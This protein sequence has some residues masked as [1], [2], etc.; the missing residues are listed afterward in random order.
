MY[1]GLVQME[2]PFF[3]AE[4]PPEPAVVF[5][6]QRRARKYILRICPD[7]SL[8]VTIPRGGSRRGAEAFVSSQRQWTERERL[9]V[10]AQ[11]APVV[12][13]RNDRI[14]L[15]GVPVPLLVERHGGASVLVLG[16]ARVRVREDG[17]NLRGAAETALR[18]IAARDLIPRLRQ[19]AAR[20]GLEVARVTIR[21]QRTRWGSC[22][23]AGA[24]ALNFRLVQMPPEVCDYVLVHE[25][26]HLRQQD[27][28]RKFWRL[29]EQACPGFREAERWLRRDGRS[30]F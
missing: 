23:R 18:Q 24:I 16:G 27:H 3:R 15:R 1:A 14:L 26:M 11:H 28:S 7:G 19:L 29:V 9:R 8:R 4:P 13:G 25:L 20:Y 5:V 2:L 22:S 12:W 21:N 10:V 30:L 17:V 6:R